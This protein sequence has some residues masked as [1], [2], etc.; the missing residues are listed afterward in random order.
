MSPRTL[1]FGTTYVDTPEKKKLL[2]QWYNLL[3]Q[4]NRQRCE[5]GYVDS[6]SPISVPR[7]MPEALGIMMPDNI[8]HLARGGMDG[9]GRA[10]CAGLDVAAGNG[11]E[12]VAHV[13][14]DSL[15]RLDFSR[16][17]ER[18]QEE[19]IAV[20]SIPVTG[21]KHPEKDW[22]ETGLMVFST[23]YLRE[24]NMTIRYD[25]SNGKNDYPRTPEYR[26]RKLIGSELKMMPW[27][28]IRNDKG[29]V[30]AANVNE[31]DWI[32]HCEDHSVYDKYME[33][34]LNVT[35]S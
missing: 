25:W 23:A 15:C 26:V 14:G 4:N 34:N 32:T 24:S 31:Y 29:E 17:A 30:T 28:G 6:A 1:I 9:W 22:V 33:E 7:I 27:R 8:G 18:M 11:F 21:T 10:F 20:A 5:Y 13:E 16:I 3:W 35:A 2:E 19:R 12:Y